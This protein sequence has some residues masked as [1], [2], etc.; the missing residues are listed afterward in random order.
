[1]NWEVSQS[2]TP[3]FNSTFLWQ[4]YWLVTSQIILFLSCGY[5]LQMYWFLIRIS[6]I[7]WRMKWTTMGWQISKFSSWV[8]SF[9][10]F[11]TPF[12][13]S[14]KTFSS[15]SFKTS[16][17]VKWSYN[18]AALIT[19]CLKA[20]YQTRFSRS[21]DMAFLLYKFFIFLFEN[22]APAL[23]TVQLGC[24]VTSVEAIYRI[25]CTMSQNKQVKKR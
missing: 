6:L 16:K 3:T 10:F 14:C 2:D 19:D 13:I 1:M 21:W 7:N 9:F 22:L 20:N 12:L 23:P 15:Q 24:G 25:G 17:A 5:H 11:K 8:K 4:L 18:T